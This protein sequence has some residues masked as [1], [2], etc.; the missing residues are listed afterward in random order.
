MTHEVDLE[1]RL[2]ELEE[3]LSS[4]APVTHDRK[5][6]RRRWIIPAASLAICVLVTGIAVISL[7]YVKNSQPASSQPFA[8]AQKLAATTPVYVP[9]DPPKEFQPDAQ[10]F[11]YTAGVVT[12]QYL[13]Q[14]KQPVAVSIQQR[15]GSIDPSEFNPTKE[16]STTIGKAYLTEVEPRVSAAVLNDETFMLINA[17]EGV[18]ASQMELF[19]NSLRKVQQ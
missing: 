5:S 6:R 18:P 3:K 14:G 8:S 2:R 11:S 12:Y 15:P 19:V 16:F 17:P 1:K 7:L 10:S 4:S 13:Y 9:Q